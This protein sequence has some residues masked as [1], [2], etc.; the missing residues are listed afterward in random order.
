MSASRERKKRMTAEPQ[1]AVKDTASKTKKL[2]DGILLA[3]AVILV[4]AIVFGS[5]AV[6]RV[7]WNKTTVLTVGEHKISTVEFNYFFNSTVTELVNSYGS[8]L[9]IIGLDASAPLTEQ[10]VPNTEEGAEPQTWAAYLADSAKTRAVNYYTIYDDAVK[11]GFTL[12]Q[13]QLDDI[14]TQIST[15]STY[16]AIY[17][18]TADKYVANMYGRGCDVDSYRDFLTLT[19]TYSAYIASQTYSDSE[20]ADRYA[21]DPT[22]FDRVSYQLYT[23]NASSYAEKDEDGNTKEVTDENRASAKAD[24]EAILKD[25]Q[26]E[27]ITDYSEQSKTYVTSA[28]SEDAANWMFGSSVKEGDVKMF[29]GENVYYVAKFVSRTD[30][31]YATVNALQIFIKNDSTDSTDSSSSSDS[32]SDSTVPKTAAEKLQ[33]IEDSLK[34]DASEENFRK[35]ITTYSDN[36]NS[37]SFTQ[38]THKS[39]SNQEVNEWLFNG[40]RTDGET[41]TFETSE[42]TYVVMFLNYDETYKNLLVSNALTN[43]WFEALTKDVPY[44]YNAKAAMHANV[45]YAISDVF[46]LKSNTSAS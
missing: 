20:L 37:Y 26:G 24:A 32:S 9:S 18:L 11:N 30:N 41:K 17:G 43:E 42:G 19:Q 4:M 34:E 46:N 7:H 6:Y 2:S 45:D 8:Y 12:T 23:A 36:K 1:S 21:Q 33:A 35:L 27:K 28:I 25:F 31:D 29:E 44:D 40:K 39:I 15:I 22:E 5:I 38:A 3:A 14:D 10:N 16:A 13:E